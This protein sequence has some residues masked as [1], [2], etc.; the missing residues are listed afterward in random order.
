MKKLL[1]ITLCVTLLS[2]CTSK[3]EEEG[4]SSNVVE[5]KQQAGKVETN[6]DTEK[7]EEIEKDTEE[8]TKEEPEEIFQAKRFSDEQKEEMQ[9]MF[10]N[11]A[12][13]RAEIGNMGVS[14]Y[15]F[16]H[17]NAGRG[18]W[19]AYTIDGHAQVQ[20]LD[21]PGFDAFDLHIIG[22]VV[23]FTSP[24]N[25]AGLY[26]EYTS[27]AAGYNEENEPGT[28]IHKYILVDNG[29]VYELVSNEMNHTTGFS[30]YTD[31]GLPPSHSPYHLE[32]EVSK[33]EEAQKEWRRILS[34]YQ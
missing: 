15:F 21:L 26:E 34:L 11:W 18:D 3:S 2:A 17:G 22:G 14:K 28:P 10:L 4:L 24:L 33:D 16:N 8:V 13:E 9:E 5:R 31:D 20:N 6:N 1:L 32:F 27:L 19:F 12:I 25:G 7:E 23:F 30:E 29:I